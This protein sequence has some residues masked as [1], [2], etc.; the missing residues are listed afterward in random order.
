MNEGRIIAD[1]H[2]RELA[3]LLDDA[4]AYSD[5]LRREIEQLRQGQ[6]IARAVHRDLVLALDEMMRAGMTIHK[7]SYPRGYT[8]EPHA[9]AAPPAVRYSS[10]AEAMMAWWGERHASQ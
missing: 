8:V 4:H 1:E 3:E 2:T 9:H 10:A 5:R 6:D 7:W